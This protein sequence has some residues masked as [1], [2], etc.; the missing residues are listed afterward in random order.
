M[1]NADQNLVTNFSIP[2]PRGPG[3][4]SIQFLCFA[5]NPETF[6]SEAFIELN[7]QVHTTVIHDRLKELGASSINIMTFQHNDNNHSAASA[8]NRVISTAK[9]EGFREVVRG[10]CNPKL[11]SKLDE[12]QAKERAEK[13]ARNAEFD[14]KTQ[15]AI[16]MSLGEIKDSMATKNEISHLEEV[17]QTKSDE[18]KSSFVE[19]KE[20]IKVDYKET[21]T[22]QAVTITDQTDIITSLRDANAK[23]NE[24]II[25]NDRKMMNLENRNESLENRNESQRYIIAKLNAEMKHKEQ[26][27]A[28]RN[29]I[30][31]AKNQTI[32][33]LTDQG[34]STECKAVIDQMK[35][36]LAEFQAC[37]KRKHDA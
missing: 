9:S 36:V 4:F 1:F 12:I 37:K 8:L 7:E 23:L 31:E 18:I 20:A 17:T 33:R 35:E 15:A 27:I 29:A 19:M 21:I 16:K 26:Q 25:N 32:L 13:Q 10:N 30:I 34:T 11:A 6:V 5:W 28:E 22:R 24:A 3:D 14:E 2:K